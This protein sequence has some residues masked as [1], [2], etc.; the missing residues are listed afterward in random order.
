MLSDNQLLDRYCSEQAEAEFEELV[1]RHAALVYRTA[2]RQLNG[3][4]D[5]ARDVA[6]TVFADL[7]QKARSLH[8]H[9]SLAGWLYT[10]ARFASAKMARS[11]QRRQIRELAV[12][13]TM[14]SHEA[15]PSVDPERLRP[16]IDHAMEELAEERGRS[17][18]FL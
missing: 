9:R 7:A 4:V 11:E 8:G 10:S 17:A 6:Q 5:L 1:R 18:P 13:D 15:P 14:N 3:D 16:L 2:L 12:S